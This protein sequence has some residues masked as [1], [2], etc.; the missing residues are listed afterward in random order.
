MNTLLAA[1]WHMASSFKPE[2]QA[3]THNGMPSLWLR[4]ADPYPSLKR[5]PAFRLIQYDFGSPRTLSPI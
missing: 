5:E 4:T 3:E 2:L 1:S